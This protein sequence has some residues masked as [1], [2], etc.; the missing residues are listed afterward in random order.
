VL[1]GGG[2][3]FS[4]HFQKAIPEREERETVCRGPALKGKNFTKGMVPFTRRKFG[5]G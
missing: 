5:R 4:I 2:D 3:R 1:G